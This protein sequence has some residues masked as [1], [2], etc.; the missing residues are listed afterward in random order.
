MKSVVEVR[1]K[2]NVRCLTV[3]VNEKPLVVVVAVAK[4]GAKSFF[5]GFK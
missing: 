3:V 4:N 2:L 1:M 5:L